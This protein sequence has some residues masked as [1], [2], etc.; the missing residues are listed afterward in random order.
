MVKY[1][2]R[3]AYVI[4]TKDRYA[5]EWC[6]YNFW[7]MHVA[8][9]CVYDIYV[10]L[11]WSIDSVSLVQFTTT[12]Y[13]YIPAGRWKV[14]KGHTNKSNL[15]IVDSIPTRFTIALPSTYNNSPSVYSSGLGVCLCV[16]PCGLQS[17]RWVGLIS[18]HHCSCCTPIYSLL[19]LFCPSAVKLIGSHQQQGAKLL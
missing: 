3:L 2:E 18:L 9:D 15:S 10:K 11:I 1:I 16:C 17:V 4:E 14:L 6:G 8:S 13:K 19:F 7:F 12:L 5:I